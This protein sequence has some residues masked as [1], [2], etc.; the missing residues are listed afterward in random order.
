MSHLLDDV[1]YAE[2]LRLKAQQ[3]AIDAATE[4]I[5]A[6]VPAEAGEVPSETVATS[7]LDPVVTPDAPTS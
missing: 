3:E 4:A 7:T 5:P 1:Q 2:Y 6:S